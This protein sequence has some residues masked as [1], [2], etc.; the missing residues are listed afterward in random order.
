MTEFDLGGV[1]HGTPKTV[2]LVN[3]CDILCDITRVDEYCE[4]GTVSLFRLSHTLEHVPSQ[5]YV[6]F[7]KDL[8]RKLKPGG[9]VEVVQ[10]DVGRVLEMVTWKE[11]PLRVARLPIFTP[12]DRLRQNPHH[13]HFNMW[14]EE[15][16]CEDF[17]A[18]GY[19]TEGFDAGSWSF[20]L[21]DELFPQESQRYRG[22]QIPNL[23]VRAYK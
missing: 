12:A 3:P 20:D 14:D 23:G 9:C 15:M 17:E 10:T 21:I 11:I 1:G 7:L 16:L 8:H 2:N 6:Q 19:R 22:V 5:D 13:L 4:D 18:L